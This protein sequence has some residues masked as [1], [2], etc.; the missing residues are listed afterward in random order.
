MVTY[1]DST[2]IDITD[3]GENNP[4]QIKGVVFVFERSGSGWAN[5]TETAK[6]TFGKWWLS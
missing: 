5:S 1:A 4:G 2:Y 3:D 6:L